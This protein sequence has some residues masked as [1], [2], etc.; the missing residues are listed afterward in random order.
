MVNGLHA[1]F[2]C[3]GLLRCS[4][5]GEVGIGLEVRTT[6]VLHCNLRIKK[7]LT[8][9][10]HPLKAGLSQIS[11]CEPHFEYHVPVG[12]YTGCSAGG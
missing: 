4:L 10:L 6:Y 2:S 7:R 8:S 3:G 12:R 5:T 1:V 9:Q 11:Q